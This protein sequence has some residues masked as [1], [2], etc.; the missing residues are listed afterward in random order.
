[1]KEEGEV[2][3]RG[4]RSRFS[5]HDMNAVEKMLKIYDL[6][7][8]QSEEEKLECSELIV[9]Y[10]CHTY[11]VCML[12]QKTVTSLHFSHFIPT[13]VIFNNDVRP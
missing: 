1:M 7:S 9:K 6:R 3:E 13:A 4:G 10:L 8:P 12:I 5:G 11:M 2:D